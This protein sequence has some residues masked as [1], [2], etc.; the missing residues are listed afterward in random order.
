[1]WDWTKLARAQQ[2][3]THASLAS[4]SGGR[5]HGPGE[6]YVRHPRGEVTWAKAVRHLPAGPPGGVYP[7]KICS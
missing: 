6:R 7:G 5:G 1:M 4:V 2:S 3:V